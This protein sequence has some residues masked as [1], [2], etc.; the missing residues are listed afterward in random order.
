MQKEGSKEEKPKAEEVEAIKPRAQPTAPKKEFY[1]VIDDDKGL[2]QFEG[3]FNTRLQQMRNRKEQFIA[4]AGSLE[5]FYRSYESY[6]LNKNEKGELVYREWAPDAKALSLIG[7]FNFWNREA[8]PC[9]KDE[10]GI[11]ELN[12][13]PAVRADGIPTI[14]HN[15]KLKCCVTTKSGEKLDRVPAWARYSTQNPETTL[16]EMRHWDPP[17]KY[18]FNHPQPKRPLSVKIYEAHVGMSSEQGEVA[19]YRYFAEHRLPWIHQAGYTVI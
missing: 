16:Y 14:A 4:A 2:K 5:S 8:N 18:E 11:W 13:G 1:P 3:V 10:F 19:S 9:K 15:S 6:G 7:D 12:L 17:T